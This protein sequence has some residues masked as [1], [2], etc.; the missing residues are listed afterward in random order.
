MRDGL[1]RKEWIASRAWVALCIGMVGVALAAGAVAQN[2]PG[3]DG[4]YLTV[5]GKPVFITGANYVPSAGWMLILE[6]WNPDAVDHD[7][8]A[9]HKL[10]VT[11][12]RFATLWPLLEPELGKVSQEKLDRVNELVTIAH[13]N[14]ISVTVSPISGWMSGATF[15]PKWADGELFT[16]PVIVQGEQALASAMAR[17][18]KDNPGLLGYDFGNEVSAM[19]GM[20]HLDPT[21]AETDHWMGAIYQA[22]HD[23]DPGH[24]ATDGLGGFGGSFDIAEIGAH[25]DYMPVHYYP[26][27]SGT[28][29]QDPWVGQRTTYG[30]NY[31]VS[32]AAMMGKPVLVQEIGCS[33]YWVPVPEIAKF[34]RL[35]LMS[36]WAQGAAGYFWWGSHNIDRGFHVPAEYYMRKYSLPFFADGSFDKLEYSM[37][38]LDLNNQPKPYALE[39]QRW[40]AVIARLGVGWKDELPAAYVLFPEHGDG[41]KDGPR[42]MTAFTLAKQAHMDVRMWPEGKTIPRDA[43]AVIVPG[44]ALS[45]KGKVAVRAYLDQGGIVYQSY[46]SD[47]SELFNVRDAGVRAAS[48]TLIGARSAGLVSIGEHVRAHAD[49][50][51]MEV[52]PQAG[53]SVEM[54]LGLPKGRGAANAEGG[55]AS[56]NGFFFKANVGKGTYYYLATNLEDALAKTY[57]PW[58]EDDSNLIYSALR[59]DGGINID[60]K[61]VE[62]DVKTRGSERIL[63]LLNHSNRA[64]DVVVRS[65]GA[66]RLEDYVS[67]AALGAGE[68]IPLHLMPGEVVVAALRR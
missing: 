46:A 13:R 28:L 55:E 67:H 47:F 65:Q 36:A 57:N 56:L 24:P 60:S 44:F 27:F 48:P 14:G 35:T 64:Q 61:F 43:A 34:L 42:E 4:A 40:A 3:I 51:L 59:P 12:I 66:L 53:Q 38:L 10:G 68:E 52:A 7:M 37:G 29:D 15:I 5:D 33:E 21:P 31:L 49:L 9:L 30:V 1:M 18:L 20:M 23:A 26:Y 16:D 45:E 22:F 11:S 2:S 25:A 17:R 50:K 6:H 32:Y 19:A 41:D 8:A 58:D 63:L 62:L 54:L 39:Y